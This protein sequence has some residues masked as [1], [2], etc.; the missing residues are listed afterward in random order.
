MFTHEHKDFS[1]NPYPYLKDLRLNDPI[2][3]TPEGVIVLTRYDDVSKFLKSQDYTR[4]IKESD[5]D[6]VHTIFDLHALDHA[7]LR[8]FV[9][10]IFSPQ[11]IKKL[12]DSMDIRIN[13]HISKALEKENV[14]IVNDIAL[15][16]VFGSLSS[17]L[18][19]HSSDYE[20]IKEW[21]GAIISLM[22]TMSSFET[23]KK[24]L[25]TAKEF[26]IHM[27]NS[28]Y[29]KNYANT[30]SII[31]LLKNTEIDNIKL[32]PEELVSMICIIYIAGFETTIN[33]IASSLYNLMGK[34]EE[35]YKI[36]NNNYPNFG[37]A[38][39]LLRYTSTVQLV[40]RRSLKDQIFESKND[41]KIIEKD[42]IVFLHL[43]S[44]NRDEDVFSSAEDI[45]IGRH[46]ANRHLA[47]ASGA[48]YCLGSN[49]AKMQVE[50]VVKGFLL[51]VK[52]LELVEE[53]ILRN[54]ISL[55]GYDHLYM[56]Y[57]IV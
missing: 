48:H 15:P 50:K 45:N 12:S 44:A 54:N 21:A 9:S 38:D 23:K 4:Q 41:S 51:K 32:T 26:F 30:N 34:E 37:I 55:R 11:S 10:P 20:H 31:P 18:G 16:I 1:K 13:K 8:R 40:L 25:K 3:L 24:G 28:I 56:R 19:I 47:F 17:M 35:I 39:E 14:D 53:P 42:Q 46:N 52:N 22:D 7:K 6:V 49:L 57:D 27:T 43:G 5:S 29:S 33:S 2:H 36:K